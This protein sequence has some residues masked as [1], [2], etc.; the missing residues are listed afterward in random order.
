LQ[1]S[2]ANATVERGE[3]KGIKARAEFSTG[4]LV[5]FI[6][7][8]ER[9]RRFLG[10]WFILEVGGNAGAALSGSG[11]RAQANE[12]CR[13]GESEINHATR[14]T[15]GFGTGSQAEIKE[16][17]IETVVPNIQ[18]QID[19]LRALTPP[20]DQADEF[21][22]WLDSAEA[23]LDEVEADPVAG[24]TQ[25]AANPFADV[26]KKAAELGIDEC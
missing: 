8:T 2:F 18:S 10:N 26:N 6:Q 15:F 25:P 16:F 20:E 17:V 21:E 14:E 13:S 22:G 24:F 7:E 19:E 9:P 3:I 23:G 12:I 5:E 11:Y 4:E 1:K